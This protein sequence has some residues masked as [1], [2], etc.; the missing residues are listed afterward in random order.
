MRMFRKGDHYLLIVADYSIES[1]LDWWIPFF[2]GIGVSVLLFIV[3]VIEINLDQRGL[4]PNWLFSWLPDNRHKKEAFILVF[5]GSFILWVIVTL[6]RMGELGDV[7]NDLLRELLSP[8]R[9]LLPKRRS[10]K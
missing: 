2:W 7:I 9:F 3:M 10:R 6:A 1:G 5:L 8:F 4:I